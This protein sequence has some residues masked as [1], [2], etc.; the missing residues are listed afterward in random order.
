[1]RKTLTGYD[2]MEAVAM[3]GE[4]WQS[5]EKVADRLGRSTQTVSQFLRALWKIDRL[6]KKRLGRN[7]IR[8]SINVSNLG[9]VTELEEFTVTDVHK[10]LGYGNNNEKEEVE[11]KLNIDEMIEKTEQAIKRFRKSLRTSKQKLEIL[12]EIKGG[13]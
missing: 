9:N 5:I 6:D 2:V 1:M 3:G 11:E 10:V 13:L 12:K 7:K 8:Y 4:E